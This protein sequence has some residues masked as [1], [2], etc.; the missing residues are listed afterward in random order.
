MYNSE[1][2]AGF[3]LSYPRAR[4]VSVSRVDVRGVTKKASGPYERPAV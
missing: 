2:A 1:M 4:G 3:V